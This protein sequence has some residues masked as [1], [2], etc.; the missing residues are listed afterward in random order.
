MPFFRYTASDASGKTVEGNIQANSGQ[1]ATQALQR[2]GFTV[3]Q[4]SG[5]GTQVASAVKPPSPAAAPPRPMATPTQP[6]QAE[7]RPALRPT[8]ISTVVKP[9]GDIVRTKKGNDKY[10][11]FIFAQLSSYFRAGMNPR[12]ALQDISSK[13]PVLYQASLNEVAH[14]AGEGFRMSDVLERYPDLYP[15]HVVGIVRAGETAGFLPEAFQEVADWALPS[16][17]IKR[18]FKVFNNVMIVL[19]IGIP[20]ALGMVHAS[21]NTWDPQEAAGGEAPVAPLLLKA[22]GDQVKILIVP[23][24]IFFVFYFA[25][26]HYWRSDKMALP[27][28]RLLLKVPIIGNRV[29]AE[30]LRLFSYALSMV[31]RGGV[32][33]HTAYELALDAMPN[34][35]L[36][37]RMRETAQVSDSSTKLT[38]MIRQSNVVPRDYVNIIETGE[39]TGDVPGAAMQIA[40]GT[41]IEFQSA[42]GATK[43]VIWAIRILILVVGFIISGFLMKTFYLL[44]IHKITD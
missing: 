6:R 18:A 30:S 40:N 10:L 39:I 43:H 27:R 9:P 13:S 19:G 3:T 2:Q 14:R 12:Q 41:N 24:L 44:L 37:R 38:D 25:A 1:E 21:I 29:R 34:L 8:T 17:R 28:H 15:R 4:L 23:V 22:F 31:S 32:T 42:D 36:A 20:F 26:R 16:H 35:E 11:L 5:S 33:P 7:T